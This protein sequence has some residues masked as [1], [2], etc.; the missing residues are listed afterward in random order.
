MRRRR[1]RGVGGGERGWGRS[2]GGEREREIIF[3]LSAVGGGGGEG[4]GKV[5]L[6]AQSIVICIGESI[7]SMC[8]CEFMSARAI[9]MLVQSDVRLT[10]SLS[11]KCN[12][13]TAIG[14]FLYTVIISFDVLAT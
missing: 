14:V 2:N 6:L 11:S 10:Q 1:R 8:S 12:E 4:E 7:L 9:C 13:T 5:V 3:V